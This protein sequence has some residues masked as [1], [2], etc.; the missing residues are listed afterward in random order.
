MLSTPRRERLRIGREISRGAFGT[1]Y[2]GTLGGR[3][4]AVK[5]VHRLLLDCARENQEDLEVVL[6]GF[7]HECE[8]LET[9][10]HDNVV[11]SLGVF[12]RDGRT[13][14]VMERMEGTLDTFLRENRGNLSQKRQIEI[15]EQV[16]SGLLFL[17]QHDP[18]IL[19]RDLTAKNVLMNR[20]GSVVKISDLGQAKF[21]PS[22]IS[23][24]ST[25]VPGCVLYM[26]PECLVEFVNDPS[27]NARARFT[28]KGDIFSLGVLMLQVATQDPPSCGLVIVRGQREVERRAA[29]LAKLPP[30]HPL[31]PLILQCLEDYP[32]E[33]LSCIEVK[34]YLLAI[35]VQLNHV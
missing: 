35:Q 13:L 7:R 28:D 19:H 24:L 10:K 4:V 18:Q 21:R 2:S 32:N 1:V 5:E 15:C 26:P 27:S 20:E 22:S 25:M 14:L 12:N 9:A 8:L 3:P 33:R 17:H 23:Y 16:V 11:D 6:S 31:W 34:S 30:E 29:D